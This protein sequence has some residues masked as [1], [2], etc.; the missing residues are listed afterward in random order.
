[1]TRKLV[2]IIIKS[3]KKT[4][5]F[6]LEVSIMNKDE[7]LAKSRAENKNKDVYEQE[8]LKQASRSAV[9]VQMALATL[10]FVMQ[11]FTGGGVN[12]GLW[13]IVFSA[14]M[15]INWVKY[16]KLHRKYELLIAVAYTILVSI[17]TGYYIYNLIVSSPIQ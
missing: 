9:V 6:D 4:W 2:G 13:A 12:W 5:R 14:S 16:I 7:I 10:F 3:D 15:T 11:I 8:V 17:M 1:M